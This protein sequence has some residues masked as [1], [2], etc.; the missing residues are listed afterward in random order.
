MVVKYNTETRTA[1]SSIFI[2]MTVEQAPDNEWPEAWYMTEGD[3]ENQKA[4]NK[5]EPNQPV[6]AEILR[7]IGINYWNLPSEGFT[8]PVKSVPWDPKEAPDPKLMALRDD[9]Y[10]SKLFID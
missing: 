3:C 9:R 10:V 2:Q 7:K 4:L 1:H 8:Y 6:T 5:Q